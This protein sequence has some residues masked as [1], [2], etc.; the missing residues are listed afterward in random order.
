[1]CHFEIWPNTTKGTCLLLRKLRFVHYIT[2]ELTSFPK[3]QWYQIHKYW[4]DTFENTSFTKC[5]F[6]FI[7]FA[8]Y[9]LFCS[10]SQN[11]PGRQNV[12][13]VVLGHIF[14]MINH[15]DHEGKWGLSKSR[16]QIGCPIRSIDLPVGFYPQFIQYTLEPSRCTS[17]G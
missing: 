7:F 2:D 1:M 12:P 16:N 3:F 9:T 4:S 13:F 15:I 5:E 17:D 6:P 11:K 8:F 10:W 14:Y